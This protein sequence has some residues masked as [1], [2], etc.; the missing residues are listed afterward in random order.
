M[1]EPASTVVLSP[2]AEVELVESRLRGVSLGPGAQQYTYA[3]SSSGLLRK[4]VLQL[5]GVIGNEI[6]HDSLGRLIS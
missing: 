5:R 4:K 3:C 1:I 2:D 6:Q